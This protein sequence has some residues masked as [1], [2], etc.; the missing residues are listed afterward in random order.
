MRIIPA[1]ERRIEGLIGIETQPRNA[2][3]AGLELHQHLRQFRI[4]C[5]T[6]H[7]AHVRRALEDLLAFLLGDTADYGEDFP[8]ARVPFEMLQTI[9]NLLLCFIPD[10]A[11]VVEN[12]VRRFHGID[13]RV[14]FMEHRAH[15]FFRVV[16]IHL[17][18][19]SL[20]VEGFVHFSYCSVTLSTPTRISQTWPYNGEKRQ[21][22]T[23]RETLHQLVDQLQDEQAE[24]ARVWLEDLR[25]AADADGPPLDA[26]TMASLDR[27]LADVLEGR[28]KPLD[29][30]ERERG[31]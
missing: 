31:L 19:E 2:L 12:V 28:V 25:D 29:Q 1:R 22:M 10:A 26:V 27:G 9:E 4:A 17:A 16:S 18:P 30:Y 6:R 14:A 3:V 21:A 8:F 15:D 13:L 24:L 20:D 23:T 7:Q 11:G 5:R